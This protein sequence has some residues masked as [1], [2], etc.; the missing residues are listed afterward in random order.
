MEP[1]HYQKE[2][3]EFAKSL[4]HDALISALVNCEMKAGDMAKRNM[5]LE[6]NNRLLAS[7]LKKAVKAKDAH[8]KLNQDWLDAC[9]G[10]VDNPDDL[11]SWMSCAIHEDDEW[12]SKYVDAGIL[13]DELYRAGDKIRELEKPIEE[14]KKQI[15]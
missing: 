13:K 10:Y 15:K 2:L 8:K 11:E 9:D 5:K 3:Y 12:Y 4:D 7:N 14:L 6:K 1:T